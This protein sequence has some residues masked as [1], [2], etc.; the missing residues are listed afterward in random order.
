MQQKETKEEKKQVEII[1]WELINHK[2][3]KNIEK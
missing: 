1:R 2:I 3:E